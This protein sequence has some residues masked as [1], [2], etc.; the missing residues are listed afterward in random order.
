M[1]N[2][3][4][5]VFLTL[6]EL[7]DH[8]RPIY[9]W[10]DD[11]MTIQAIDPRDSRFDI[12]RAST[13]RLWP[14]ELAAYR[15]AYGCPVDTPLPE[16]FMGDEP[17]FLYVPPELRRTSSSPPCRAVSPGRRSLTGD[18]SEEM[19]WLEAERRSSLAG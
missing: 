5:E 18:L 3:H 9:V 13:F 1:P 8:E 14:N 7:P 15:L 19:A 16:D 17:A 6:R 4:R 2:R 11:D 12:V 10:R